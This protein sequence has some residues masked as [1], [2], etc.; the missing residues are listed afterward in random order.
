LC[1]DRKK[2]FDL[3]GVAP[4]PPSVHHHHWGPRFSSPLLVLTGHWWWWCRRR[5][6][7]RESFSNPN[8]EHEGHETDRGARVRGGLLVLFHILSSGPLRVALAC[9]P[10]FPSLPAYPRYL[11]TLCMWTGKGHAWVCIMLLEHTSLGFADSVCVC[12]CNSAVDKFPR[13]T[14]Y[15]R[16]GVKLSSFVTIDAVTR[17]IPTCVGNVRRL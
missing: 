16:R 5:L 8:G 1:C 15:V 6:R 2:S 10:P 7:N 4:V 17:P 14:C 3:S 11:P 12:V 13:G 9:F